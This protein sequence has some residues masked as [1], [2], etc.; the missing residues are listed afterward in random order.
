[1]TDTSKHECPR[2]QLK[3]NYYM[4]SYGIKHI[5]ENEKYIFNSTVESNATG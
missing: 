3:Q 1:V 2:A 4:G 5:E